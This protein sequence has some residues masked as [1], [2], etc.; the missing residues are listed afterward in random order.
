MSPKPVCASLG[1]LQYINQ[2]CSN[3]PNTRGGTWLI[4]WLNNIFPSLVAI[5]YV[6]WIGAIMSI[7]HQNSAWPLF[8]RPSPPKSSGQLKWFFHLKS[9]HVDPARGVTFVACRSHVAAKVQPGRSLIG[10]YLIAGNARPRASYGKIQV[11]ARRA[12]FTCGSTGF[13]VLIPV[14]LVVKDCN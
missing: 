13:H 3:T 5:I 11:T 8:G 14:F 10:S 12:V 9:S 4:K 6:Q 1:E 7:S 2:G